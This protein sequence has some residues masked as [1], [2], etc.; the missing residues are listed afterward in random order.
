MDLHE[1]EIRDEEGWGISFEIEPFR[2]ECLLKGLDD[3]ALTL[4]HEG[5]IT[6]FEGQRV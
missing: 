4:E 2:R 6:A 1:C 5:K 3:I